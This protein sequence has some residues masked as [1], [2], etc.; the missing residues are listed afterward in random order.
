[1]YKIIG[2]IF[3]GEAQY[4]SDR[5]SVNARRVVYANIL[6]TISDPLVSVFLSAFIWTRTGSLLSVALYKLGE[7]VFLPLAFYANGFL[8]RRL[9]IQQA[10]FIG[11]LLQG[12]SSMILV[13]SGVPANAQL[14]VYGALFGI[15]NGFYWANR[16]YLE[17]KETT[18]QIR[19]YF[20]GLLYSISSL[21]SIIVPVIA[22][23]FIVLGDMSGFYTSTSAYIILFAGAFA[24]MIVSAQIVR[25]GTFVTPKPEA[26]EKNS[27]GFSA[28]RRYLNIANGLIDGTDFTASLLLL[29][30]FGNEGALGTGLA[31]VAV[32][33]VIASYIYGRFNTGKSQLKTFIFGVGLFFISALA[34][35]W[36]PIFSGV[37]AYVL[38]STIA[39]AFIYITAT[40]WAMSLID[41]EARKTGIS[42]YAFIIDGEVWINTGRVIGIGLL[43]AIAFM[44][45]QKI[46]LV[47]GPVSIALVQIVFVA[48]F[49]R[50][51]DGMTKE[52]E[53]GRLN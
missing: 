47:Y 41:Q 4:F 14:F 51:R 34:L 13:L 44:Y 6:H 28:K 15:G 21:S 37:S 29:I 31:I 43:L 39:F 42:L 22:G 45:S 18:D 38:G 25:K 5:I 53:V 30:A 52:A 1:M 8:L 27:A 17:L 33:K 46:S 16:N 50:G 19:N 11:C 3:K 2:A 10:F 26:R 20:Y 23:W 48:L 9:S 7:C 24:L 49:L 32:C 40:P 36:L 12:V 35:A